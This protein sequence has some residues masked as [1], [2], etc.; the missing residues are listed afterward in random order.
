MGMKAFDVPSFGVAVGVGVL[1]GAC[2]G[3]VPVGVIV[4]V[5]VGGT[6]AVAVGVFV[7]VSVGTT[8]VAV[9][10]FVGVS[11]GGC[12]V[13]V[14]VSVAVAVGVDVGVGA[15]SGT[16]TANLALSPSVPIWTAGLLRSPHWLSSVTAKNNFSP[17]ITSR[18]QCSPSFGWSLS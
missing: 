2:T 9:G 7:G 18:R 8:G 13:A 6:V 15:T 10:V 1:A 11:V 16:Q 17:L 4:G 3:G 5:A 12:C 14:G